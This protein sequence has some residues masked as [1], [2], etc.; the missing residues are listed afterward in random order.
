MRL[1][2]YMMPHKA[3]SSASIT[4]SQIVVSNLQFV[5]K[6]EYAICYAQNFLFVR[7]KRALSLLFE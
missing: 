5:V 4:A 6:G 1:C 2:M 7:V 3:I